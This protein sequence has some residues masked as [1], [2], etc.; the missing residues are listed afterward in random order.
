MLLCSSF[1][2]RSLAELRVSLILSSND[3]PASVPAVLV[4][5]ILYIQLLCECAGTQTQVLVFAHQAPSCTKSN[6]SRPSSSLY[7]GTHRKLK[8]TY[9]AH[10]QFLLYAT[11]FRVVRQF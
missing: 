1:E 7:N 10:I 6:L 2:A 11:G 3:P 9:I 4:L 5:Q 8:I